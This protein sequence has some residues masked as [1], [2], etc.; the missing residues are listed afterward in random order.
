MLASKQK[1]WSRADHSAAGI[2]DD[3]H[4]RASHHVIMQ[5][6]NCLPRI[7]CNG[8]NVAT[9]NFNL[10]PVDAVLSRLLAAKVD[11]LPPELSSIT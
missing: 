2:T 4:R 9:R 7:L 10:Y 5:A 11:F 6:S 8:P 3:T 1:Q